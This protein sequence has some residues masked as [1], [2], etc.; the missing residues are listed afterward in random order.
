M[1]VLK[2]LENKPVLKN[3]VGKIIHQAVFQTS[4]YNFVLQ[5]YFSK[6]GLKSNF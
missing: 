2:I 1:S 3:T 6:I 4:F 5:H